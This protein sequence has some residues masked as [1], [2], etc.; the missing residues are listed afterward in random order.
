MSRVVLVTG[1]STGIGLTT[2]VA[3][4]RRGDRVYA[5]MRALARGDELRRLV[6]AE[7]LDVEL[8]QLDVTEDVSVRSAVGQIFAKEGRLDV[9]VNNA[10][11]GPFAPIERST[12]EEWR[13]TIDTNLLG[14]MRVTRAALPS[15][16]TNGGGVVITIS[17]VAGRLPPVPTQGA[18]AA[19]KFG[20]EALS[21]VLRM[22]VASFGVQVVVI[23]PGFFK[24]G[25]EERAGQQAAERE[26]REHGHDDEQLD[27]RE[28]GRAQR[29]RA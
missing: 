22:E 14:P 1:C 10:G 13:S 26:R 21:D 7:R 29:S 2:A 25:I 6:D 12:D 8:I 4:A 17:S 3:F 24:T 15:M 28:T 5:S 16:R 11:V 18:Y 20:L 23:Q 19:S 9:V 27:Q